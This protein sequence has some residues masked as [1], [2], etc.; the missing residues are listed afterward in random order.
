MKTG[1]NEFIESN[2]S[3]KELIVVPNP[4]VT[5]KSNFMMDLI[6]NLKLKKDE[7]K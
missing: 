5:N 3:K 7:N 1:I 2:K 4:R 6:F